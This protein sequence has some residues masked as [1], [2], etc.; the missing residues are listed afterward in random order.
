MV[1]PRVLWRQAPA[2]MELLGCGGMPLAMVSSFCL[3]HAQTPGLKPSRT[4]TQGL[5]MG[6]SP[7]ALNKACL[8]V[9]CV[10]ASVLPA[11]PMGLCKDLLGFGVWCCGEDEPPS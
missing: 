10:S 8:L 3:K 4:G 6:Q 11:G 5:V 7:Q 9:G 2:G 1:H